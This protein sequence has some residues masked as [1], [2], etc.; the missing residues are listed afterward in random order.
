MP[1]G[2]LSTQTLSVI[3]DV[4]LPHRN[5][6]ISMNPTNLST[7]AAWSLFTLGIAHLV[8]ALAKFKEPL[9]GAFR[10]G[11]V[12]KFADP[13]SR[14][15][16]FWFAIFALP[17]TA[18]GHSAIH[19]VATG[20]LAILRIIGYYVMVASIIGIAAFPK[21]PFPASLAVAAMLLAAGYGW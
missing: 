5:L 15:T 3:D 13:E 18:A 20:D 14:R 1:F 21:S 2:L 6:S 11:F 4:S 10:A 17:L 12:G 8:F 19:A 7:I 9:F 16:A